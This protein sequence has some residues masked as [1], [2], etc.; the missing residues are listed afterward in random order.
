MDNTP[1]LSL[2]LL[3][4][5]QDLQTTFHDEAIKT[6]DALVM[7]S[8]IDRDLSSPPASPSEGDRYIVKAPGSGDDAWDDNNV[9]AFIDGH[10]R[11]HPPRIGWTCYVQDE[12]ALVA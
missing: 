9:V 2:P 8:V 3:A 4:Y 10:W 7:L 12:A 6:L 5:K 1:L 11:A